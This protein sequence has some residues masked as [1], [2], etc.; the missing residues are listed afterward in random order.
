[1]INSGE[2][3]MSSSMEQIKEDYIQPVIEFQ[4][5]QQN[6]R[7]VALLKERDWV[8]DCMETGG[9]YQVRVKDQQMALRELPG[10]ITEAGGVLL[11]YRLSK[12]TLEDIFMKVVTS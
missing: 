2:I 10:L 11:Q 6:P 8:E 5:E 12:L 7:L 1:M 3:E 9:T 4:L